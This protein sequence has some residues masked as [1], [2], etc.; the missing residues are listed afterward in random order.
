MKPYYEDDAVTVYHG[1]CLELLPYFARFYDMALTSPPYGGLRD[2]G[3]HGP[4]DLN[5]VLELLADGLAE[6]GVLMWNTADQTVDGSET[7]ESLR[8]ALHAMSAGLRLH[9]TMIYCREAVVFPGSNRYHPAWEY[10]F[11]FS[12]GAPATFNGIRDRKNKWAGDKVHGTRR[13]ANGDVHRPSRMGEL[14]PE[15]GLRWNW[16]VMRNASQEDKNIAHPAQMPRAMAE[17][18][19]RT[20]TNPGDL[21]LD[22]FAGSGTTL[23]AAKDL[24]RKA[25]GIEIDES[26]CELIAKR[27]AQDVLEIAV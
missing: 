22:P 13:E 25:I 12:K 3:G 20:W 2:Y 26:Y 9:D 24:G 27:C 16:W 19:I 23:R 15:D 5:E 4:V 17:G 14:V 6:G 1:D 21:V 10:M 18:H 11:V 8:Q 7:G